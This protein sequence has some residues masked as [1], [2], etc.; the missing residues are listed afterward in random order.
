MKFRLRFKVSAKYPLPRKAENRYRQL[1]I[2]NYMKLFTF[3]IFQLL[4]LNQIFALNPD[5]NYQITPDSL[6]LTFE[7]ESILT[8][9]NAEIKLWNIQPP[10]ETNNENTIIISYGDAGNMSW[11]LNQAAILSQVGYNVILFD[12]RGFGQSSDFEI[13]KD[14]LYYN[15][16]VTDLVTVIKWTKK[17]VKSKNIGLLSFSMG[18]IM[19]TIAVQAEPVDF[20]IAEGYVLNPET[21][22][23]RIKDLK[24]KEILLPKNS[25]DYKEKISKIN[26]PILIFSGT[27][28]IVTTLQDSKKIVSERKNRK[29]IEFVGNHLG[30]FQALSKEYF[31]QIYV[32][33]ITEFIQKECNRR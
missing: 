6:G 1:R 25:N 30:G 9:D 13:N 22:K 2:K 29:L 15:E 7:S 8:P 31:G 10:I 11:W 28:D 14:M 16:F 33:D 18:T 19:S 20:M 24:G 5:R 21:I 23:Q 26:F 32:E 3:L 17:N 12:Y 27:E 4:V